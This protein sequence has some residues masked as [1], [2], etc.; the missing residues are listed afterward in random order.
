MLN[1]DP[2]TNEA[3]ISVPGVGAAPNGFELAPDAEPIAGAASEAGAGVVDR[4]EPKTNGA[5][6]AFDVTAGAESE[7][8]DW[9]NVGPPEGAP[10]EDPKKSPGVDAPVS[11]AG[12]P[13]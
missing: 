8:A 12:G 10:E 4:P 13:N 11:A 1:P 3:G 5:L 6:L 2:V 7:A 9:P